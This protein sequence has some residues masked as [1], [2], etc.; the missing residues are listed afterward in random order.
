MGTS[1]I[2][3][4]RNDKNPLLP[5]DYDESME[6]IE[7]VTW[8]TVKSDLSKY[9]NRQGDY[10]SSRHI[11]SQYVR[12]AGGPGRATSISS[13]GIKTG[14]QI[15]AFFHRVA[16]NGYR[17]TLESLGIDFED[18]SIQE[19]FSRL[20]DVLSPSANTKE[21]CVARQ[22][23]Q[24]A[25]VE[26]YDYV[27]QNNLD[28]SVLDNM[29]LDLANTVLCNYIS[30]YIWMLMMKDLESR[31][32]KYESNPEAAYRMEM[33]FKETI[34]SIVEIEYKKKGD[35][36]TGNIERSISELYKACYSVL[37]GVV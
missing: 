28:L 33:D 36:I 8:Q 9:I 13:A 29:P 17:S 24:A 7:P 34:H 19:V 1:S 11:I 4:G 26:I 10:V 37:G 27:E 12:A 31:F 22:A 20:I 15:G 23:A 35:I 30:S 25:L 2:F 3:H 6:Q 18:K 16:Q 14:S 21:E 32:E 5:D